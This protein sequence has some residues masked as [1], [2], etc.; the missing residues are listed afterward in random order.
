MLSFRLGLN[1]LA[2]AW[3]S[4]PTGW[5]AGE[6]YVQPYHHPALQAHALTDG[7]RLLIVV[8]EKSRGV[9]SPWAANGFQMTRVAP[10]D[11]SEE[12]ERAGKW[13]LDFILMLVSNRE[14]GGEVNIHTGAWGT[15]PV[16]VLRADD[17]LWCH[18][19]PSELYRHTRNKTLD[20]ELTAHFLVT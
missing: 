18:W 12:L 2:S 14:H 6:S 4:T 5:R 17:I 15:A 13:P 19:D 20:S 9:S 8:R 7:K 16:Y 10:Q 1:D 3:E 11:L